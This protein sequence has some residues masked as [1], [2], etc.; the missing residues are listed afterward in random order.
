MYTAETLKQVCDRLGITL[1][2]KSSY[3]KANR[4]SLSE[5]GVGMEKGLEILQEV[6]STFSLPILTDVH[7]SWQC[8]PVA[9]VADVL[10][11]PAFLSRQTDLLVAAAQ[12]GKVVNV[13]RNTGDCGIWESTLFFT[14]LRDEGYNN[15]RSEDSA[16]YSWDDL[17][18]AGAGLYT[19]NRT[20]AYIDLEMMEKRFPNWMNTMRGAQ[21]LF[22]KMDAMDAEAIATGD[23]SKAYN[24]R[25][26]VVAMQE[27]YAARV[28]ELI[29]EG[30]TE[31][32]ANDIAWSEGLGFNEDFFRQPAY[33]LYKNNVLSGGDAEYYYDTDSDGEYADSRNDFVNSDYLSNRGGLLDDGTAAPATGDPHA[34]DMRIIETNIYFPDYDGAFYDVDPYS[35]GT[36]NYYADYG[37]RDGVLQ[38]I[39]ET[40]PDYYELEWL[41]W[42]AGLSADN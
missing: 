7:E 26:D 39:L 5:R 36:V 6:K 13:K 12:T 14:D 22:D 35:D 8:A 21:A 32:E 23:E 29:A 41:M 37:L 34:T 9:E 30:K 40:I 19:G 24:R 20:N 2:F 10:Q 18:R 16:S 31:L 33:N 17:Y 42:T 3:D 1:Y 28:S 15:G 27:A 25:R 4:T 38:T 11:I